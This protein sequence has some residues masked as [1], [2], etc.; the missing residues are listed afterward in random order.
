VKNGNNLYPWLRNSIVSGFILLLSAFQLEAQRIIGIGTRYND[1]FR[2]WVITTEDEKVQGELRMRWEMRDD[3]TEW[4][5]RI[6]DVVATVEQKWRDDPNLW[7]IRCDGIVVN[8]KTVW[9]NEFNRWKLTDGNHHFNWGT[10]YVNLLDE[11]KTDLR[12]KE[13]M[14]VYTYWEGDPREWVVIDDLDPDV[15]TAMRIAMIFLA[16]HFSAP[17]I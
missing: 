15:S 3:W 13:Q 1:T 7:E 8:A 4:D 14:S 11:W 2:E 6:G 5:I 12:T 16:I 10:K 17:R 9:P